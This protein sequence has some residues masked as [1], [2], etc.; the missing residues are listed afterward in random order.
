MDTWLLNGGKFS[1]MR[2]CRFSSHDHSWRNNAKAF[3]DNEEKQFS[4]RLLSG[5]DVIEQYQQFDQPCVY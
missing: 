2:S 4:P 3:D 1:Y 5:D